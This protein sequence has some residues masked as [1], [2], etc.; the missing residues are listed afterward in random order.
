MAAAVLREGHERLAP[1]MQNSTPEEQ[2]ALLVTYFKQGG[3][4]MKK[5]YDAR[6]EREG[7]KSDMRPGEGAIMFNNITTIRNILQ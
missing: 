4:T 3:R 2:A 5:L 6:V 7:K 1:Y